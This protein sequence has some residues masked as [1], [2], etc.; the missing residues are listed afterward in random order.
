VKR[1]VATASVEQSVVSSLTST[2]ARPWSRRDAATTTRMHR[3]YTCGSAASTR[4]GAGAGRSDSARI[5][6]IAEPDV[7]AEKRQWHY[8]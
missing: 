5:G 8:Q 6:D 2:V 3:D 7:T 1:H 4:P